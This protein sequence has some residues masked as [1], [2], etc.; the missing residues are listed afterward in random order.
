VPTA[1]IVGAGIA[2]LAAGRALHDL[3]FEVEI[4]EA[5]PTLRMGGA[6]ITLWPNA[7]RALRALGL[8]DAVEAIGRPVE[9]GV[10]LTSAGEMIARAPLDR[11]RRR[12]GPLLSFHRD[13]LLTVLAEQAGVPI[14]FDAGVQVEDGLAWGSKEAL[15]PDL[16]IGA[17]G[18]GSVV[19]ELVA[20]GTR[21]R[22]AGYGAWRGIASGIGIDEG[23]VSETFGPGR[24]FGIVPLSGG[25]TYWFATLSGARGDEDL[26]GLFAGW[27]EPI[28]E[29]I[30]ATPRAEVSFLQLA[31]LPRLPRWCE[32]RVA[33]VGDAAHAM[34]PNLGQGAAQALLDVATLQREL[35]L[36]PQTQGLRAYESNRKATAEKIVRRSR[37]VGRVGQLSHPLAMRA[38][39]ALARAVPPALMAR[40]M[41]K[42]VG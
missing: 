36:Q 35:S 40:E 21:A 1:T 34:T 14:R 16:L 39:D 29:L 12:F 11:L 28:S 18:I 32:N 19:R 17:D 4:L 5:A 23:R 20:P 38:R 8:G 27:H 13:E 22:P 6:G 9:E 37:A 15:H 26:E 30:A 33:L 3:G 10:T 31:D 2:G 41:G 24:R 25:R 7:L 42:V